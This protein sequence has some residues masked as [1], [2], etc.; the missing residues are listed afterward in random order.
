MLRI[1]EKLVALASYD[2]FKE[3]CQIEVLPQF[4]DDDELDLMR[5]QVETIREEQFLEDL[6]GIRARL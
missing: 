6:Y 4:Y 2:L 1:F 5:E 3:C